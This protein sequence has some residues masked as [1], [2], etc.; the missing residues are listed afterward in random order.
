MDEQKQPNERLTKEEA[1]L[2]ALRLMLEND[3][4][5]VKGV[6]VYLTARRQKQS[7]DCIGQSPPDREPDTTD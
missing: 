6:T 7:T 4:V 3:L 5:E 2:E 1:L